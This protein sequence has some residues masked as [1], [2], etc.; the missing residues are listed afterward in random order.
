MKDENVPFD[1]VP[2]KKQHMQ[3]EDHPIHVAPEKPEFAG[4]GEP[5]KSAKEVKKEENIGQIEEEIDE[6][7]NESEMTVKGTSSFGMD[8]KIID[9]VETRWYVDDEQEEKKPKMY[10]K[11]VLTFGSNQKVVV[12]GISG[13]I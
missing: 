8:K 11:I 5:L 4:R 9:I 12:G 1:G 7:E 13:D 10:S 3:I 6:N 2:S